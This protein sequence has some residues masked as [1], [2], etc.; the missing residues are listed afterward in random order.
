MSAPDA[1][2]RPSPPVIALTGGT[3][4]VGASLLELLL[5]RGHRVRALA[6]P[7]PGRALRRHARLEWVEG[8]LDQLE[9]IEALV[10]G[11]DA[12]LHLAYEPAGPSPVAGR[13][14]V[15]HWI[16]TNHLA[17]M[18]LLERTAGTGL[19]QMVYVSSLAVYGDEPDRDPL[20]ERFARDEDFPLWPLDFYGAMR[21]SVEKMVVTAQR[22]FGLNTS[23]FRLGCV[24]GLREPPSETPFATTVDEALRHGE[25]RSTIGSYCLS[26][27]DAARVLADAVGD[28][29]VAG[30]VYN[31]FDRWVDQAEAAPI[32][33]RLLGHA[34]RVARPPAL[35]PRSP[36]LGGRLRARHGRFETQAAI[37]ALLEALVER[38]RPATGPAPGAM[39]P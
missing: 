4:L 1:A 17:S 11:V 12:V 36:I 29:E 18:R 5:Q 34:V 31:T 27:A 15:E 13:S 22:A 8:R 35:E 19:R 39:D 23:V 2:T 9:A 10:A 37:E 20:G 6:R 32:L 26:V 16:V 21:A 33:A 7:R 3:G 30:R 25:L 38:L 14:D 28:P 24:L